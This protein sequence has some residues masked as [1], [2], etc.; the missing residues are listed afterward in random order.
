MSK[1][2]S[3]GAQCL[4]FTLDGFDFDSVYYGE[5]IGIVACRPTETPTLENSLFLGRY[6]ART[7]GYL[8]SR[9]D[10]ALVLVDDVPSGVFDSNRSDVIGAVSIYEINTEHNF[11][12]G[13]VS[14]ESLRGTGSFVERDFQARFLGYF[15]HTVQM[16]SPRRVWEGG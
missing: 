8:G 1:A 9:A 16:P 2:L 6:D 7:K 11:V 10:M 15:L 5:E 3:M 4:I 12:R 13:A 14:F